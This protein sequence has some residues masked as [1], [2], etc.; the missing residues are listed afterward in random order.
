M[1]GGVNIRLASPK[2]AR[3]AGSGAEKG[4]IALKQKPAFHIC[5]YSSRGGGDHVWVIATRFLNLGGEVPLA[6]IVSKTES[7]SLVHCL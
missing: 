2:Q 5:W 6:S 3:N 4:P 7:E 1:G